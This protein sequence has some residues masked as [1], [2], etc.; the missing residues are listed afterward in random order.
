MVFYGDNCCFGRLYLIQRY[1]YR[2]DKLLED[3][4]HHHHQ[5]L[6]VWV[7]IGVQ[8]KNSESVWKMHVLGTCQAVSI[9][10]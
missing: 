9:L 2:G 5:D 8:I 1:I 4:H 7:V 6:C 10:F 3:Y